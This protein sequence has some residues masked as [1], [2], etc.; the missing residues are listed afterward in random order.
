ML[1]QSESNLIQ[2]QLSKPMRKQYLKNCQEILVLPMF[3]Q[4]LI[5]N[6]SFFS[7]SLIRNAVSMCFGCFDFVYKVISWNTIL[8]SLTFCTTDVINVHTCFALSVY[9]LFI[10]WS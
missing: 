9:F 1:N 5:Q 3:V 7:K 6:P 8:F 2:S 10:F 4:Y